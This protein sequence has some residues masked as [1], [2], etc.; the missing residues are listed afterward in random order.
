V[1]RDWA[2]HLPKSQ[3]FLYPGIKIG[4]EASVGINAYH[5]PDGNRYWDQYPKTDS[6]D[7]RTGL[8]MQVDFAG[9][10][11]PLGYAAMR[12]M[13]SPKNG[14]PIV[15]ADVERITADYLSFL[16][17]V[18]R[19]AGFQR[20]E[21]FT[22]AGGQSVPYP[23]H[24]SYRV[25]INDDSTPGWSFY[26]VDPSTAGDLGTSLDRA[27]RQEWCAAEWLAFSRTA[28]EWAT[29]YRTTLQFRRCRFVSVYNW[30]GISKKPE[31]VA[32]L[33]QYLTAM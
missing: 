24:Y 11:P 8:D 14:A 16:A 5:Y 19:R 4:W 31:A 30:E 17:R 28:D 9:G 6:N 29:A 7:P 22:H 1:V 13:G 23:R 27:R 10:L 32:G 18:C 12:S 26:N 20:D 15:L 3:R 33:R 2:R 21:V 25:A